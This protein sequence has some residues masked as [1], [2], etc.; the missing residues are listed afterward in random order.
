MK[1]AEKAR[2]R[3]NEKTRKRVLFSRITYHV[4]RFT[5]YTLLIFWFS[6]TVAAAKSPIQIIQASTDSFLIKFEV[7]ALQFSTQE[8][9]GRTFTSISFTGATLTTDVGRP[10]LPIY[11]ELIGIPLDASP[12]A[13]VIDSRLEVRQTE[14]IIPAQPPGLA[15]PQSTFIMDRDFYRRDRPHPTKL[16]EV[17]PLGLIRRQRVARLQIQPIQYNPARSQLKIY[18]E[19]LIRIDFNST[20]TQS[21]Q[22]SKRHPTPS[23]IVEPSHAFEQLFRTKLLNYDQAKV[24]RRS[25]QNAFSCP[26]GATP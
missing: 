26:G 23:L 16:V 10:T 2:K 18:H 24:W 6:V 1:R 13:T 20:P 21:Y 25:P 5:F 11:P 4:S 12:H 19:L 15:S 22:G 17:I 7:P 9:N 14:R 3:E 8:I